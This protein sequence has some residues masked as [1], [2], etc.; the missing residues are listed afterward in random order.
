LTNNVL[1]TPYEEITK[2]CIKW[3][4]AELSNFGSSLGGC[5]RPDSDIDLLVSFA[6]D[7]NWSLIDHISIDHELSELLGRRV[8]LISKRA[9]ERSDNWPRRRAIQESAK[10][11]YAS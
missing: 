11:I 1:S 8:D 10:V 5:I 9:I 7:A 2:F 6:P 3:Q 4:I